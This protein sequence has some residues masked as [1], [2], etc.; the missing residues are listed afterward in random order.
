VASA[1]KSSSAPGATGST[2]GGGNGGWVS[3][4]S[5][6]SGLSANDQ[7]SATESHAK[8]QSENPSKNTFNVEDY[9]SYAQERNQF[10]NKE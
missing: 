10:V 6:F 2:P 4:N 5:G 9:V 7:A 1:I 8:W 3:K